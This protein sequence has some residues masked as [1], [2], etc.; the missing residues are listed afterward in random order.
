MIGRDAMTNLHHL[1]QKRLAVNDCF[2]SFH[3]FLAKYQKWD[4]N[5]Y[6]YLRQLCESAETMEEAL[7]TLSLAA[8]K[9]NLN[10]DQGIIQ[11][12]LSYFIFTSRKVNL[13]IY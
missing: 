13:C 6:G 8:L 5:M 10:G 9:S 11:V 12:W 3:A 7:A 2:A 4:S 1:A